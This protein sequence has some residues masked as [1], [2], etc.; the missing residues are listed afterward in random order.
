M[1]MPVTNCNE[2]QSCLCQLA[3]L[4]QP[5]W[6]VACACCQALSPQE[7]ELLLAIRDIKAEYRWEAGSR[8]QAHT[9]CCCVACW[10]VAGAA[11]DSCTCAAAEHD[12]V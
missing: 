5:A 7:Y 10:H 11:S 9:A 4:F 6:W 2:V 8:G 12:S 1:C 3:C